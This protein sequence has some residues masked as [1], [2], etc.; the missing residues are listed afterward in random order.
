VRRHTCADHVDLRLRYA[1]DGT[2][3]T[4]EDRGPRGNGTAEPG[5]GYG[6]TGMRERA[7]LLGGRL[8]ATPTAEGFRVELYIP[9]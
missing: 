5:L 1:D 2:W 8:D 4:V 7:E 3:L 9:A 6:L